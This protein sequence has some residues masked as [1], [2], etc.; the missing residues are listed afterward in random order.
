[1]N[2]KNGGFSKVI[3]AVIILYCLL[4]D[5]VPGP[6]DDIL[7]IIGYYLYNNRFARIEE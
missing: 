4:P 1:M 7:M 5:L 3:L 2:N 6:I